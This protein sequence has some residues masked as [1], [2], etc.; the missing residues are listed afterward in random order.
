MNAAFRALQ[1]LNKQEREKREQE[2]DA[3]AG[4][5]SGMGLSE[6]LRKRRAKEEAKAKMH[7]REGK[8]SLPPAF[9][10]NIQKKKDAAK[11]KDGEDKK[12]EV[13]VDENLKDGFYG[14]RIDPEGGKFVLYQLHHNRGSVTGTVIGR[15]ATKDEAIAKY[16]AIQAAKYEARAKAKKDAAAK[17]EDVEEGFA[18]PTEKEL[19]ASVKWLESILKDPKKLKDSGL[20]REDA[21]DNLAAAKDMLSFGKAHGSKIKP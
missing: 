1:L 7:I 13:Q 10:K 4:V 11:K 3:E 17:K 15:F 12:E 19:R 20:S 9:L 5:E 8:K 18:Q 16:E 6:E 14:Y 2:A 21:E